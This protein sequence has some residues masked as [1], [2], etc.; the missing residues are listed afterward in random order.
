MELLK[1][2]ADVLSKSRCVLPVVQR[3]YAKVEGLEPMGAWVRRIS[4]RDCRMSELE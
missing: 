2:M 3:V 1:A 4:I